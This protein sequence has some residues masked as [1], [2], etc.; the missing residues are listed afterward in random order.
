MM[1][2]MSEQ[3]ATPFDQLMRLMDIE[4]EQIEILLAKIKDEDS[5]VRL[6]FAG[7]WL[8]DVRVVFTDGRYGIPRRSDAKWIKFGYDMLNLA[9]SF[10][11]PIQ[12]AANDYGPDFVTF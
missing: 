5:I 8:D 2:R 10:R 6:R 7:R 11:K 12:D 3:T 4:T 1:A 9:S